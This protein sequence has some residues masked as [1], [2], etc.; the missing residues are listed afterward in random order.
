MHFGLEGMPASQ[1]ALGP[2]E[3]RQLLG[4]SKNATAEEAS[5][6]ASSEYSCGMHMKFRLLVIMLMRALN[7]ERNS[8]TI[9]HHAMDCWKHSWHLQFAR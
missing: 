5:E 3:A 8:P 1:A 9:C 4:V 2:D 6:I 7:G